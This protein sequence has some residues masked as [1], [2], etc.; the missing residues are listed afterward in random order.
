MQKVRKNQ[1]TWVLGSG[2]VL[3]LLLGSSLFALR[4][5]GVLE[6][7][8]QAATTTN[9]LDPTK[10][11]KNSAVLPL[12]LL[13]SEERAAQLEEIASG[14]K[15]LDQYRARYLLA[16]DLILQQQGL[17]A[18][19]WLEGLE[20]DYPVLAPQILF[21]RSQAYELNGE[22][23][24]AI[25][26]WEEMLE[27]YPDHPTTAEALYGLGKTNPEY[28]ERA[29][30]E[31]PNHPRTQEIVRSRLDKNPK[32]LD[33]LLFMV[34]NAPEANGVGSMRDRLVDKYAS[35]LTPEDW[36]AIAFGYWQTGEYR[37]AGEA[38]AKAPRTAKN[39]YRE[40]RGLQLGKQK[41]A[42]LAAYQKLVEEFP[43]AEET[44]LGLR[45]LASLSESQDALKYLDQVIEKFPKEAPEALIS[46][47]EILDDLGSQTSAAQNRQFVLTKYASSDA[48]AEYRWE[49]AQ[50]RAAEGKLEEAWQWAQPITTN[51][52]DS[53]LAP[54]AAFWVGKW[55][56]ELKRPEDAK[57]AYEHVLAKYPESYYAWRSAAMLGWNVGN[58]T[59]VRDLQ[60]E[61][62]VPPI[63]PVLP[64]GSDTLKELYRLG[65][66]TSALT[67]WQAEL[68]P[69]QERTVA[70]QFTNGMILLEMGDHLRAINQIWFLSQREKP[71]EIAEWQELRQ[72]PAY[73]H[74][75]FPIPYREDIL[76]WSEQRQLNPFLVTALIRQESRF[77]KL[78]RSSA[79]A[80]GLMQVM[81]ETG[82]WVAEKID[83]LEYDVEKPNDNI[84]LGTWFLDFTHKEYDNNSLLAL[85]SYNAGPGNVSK[86]VKKYG[87]SDPDAFIEKIP[88]PETKGY[89]E[90]VFANYWNYLR[91]YNPEVSQMLSQ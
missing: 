23:T 91:L 65:Q 51:N 55:A 90:N 27:N 31:Y 52:P 78:I 85:A 33:L 84:Q 28:W 5:T 60:P 43:D 6:K 13:S 53:S 59:T 12:V 11:D 1:I 77:E 35:D 22:R 38:Y 49:V 39:A 20:S 75:L 62:V 71:E 36:E 21:K 48:A 37:K 67:L 45:R 17:A 64:A 57:A 46:K 24:E 34:K 76:Q 18:L 42:T 41:L 61:V 89:V 50:K 9:L 32:Q 66:D 4:K 7:W 63:R 88:F 16:S 15:S 47:A 25:K 81:P 68:E 86:W 83:L 10:E 54:E 3:C 56:N 82:K 44:G 74:A 8:I 72:L 19:P 73:W 14:D 58:F 69:F 87:F 2:L 26:V 40:A 29:I 30:A 80:V 70:E 79:G